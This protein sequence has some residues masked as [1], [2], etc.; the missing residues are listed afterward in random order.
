MRVEVGKTYKGLINGAKFKIIEE[1]HPRS[2]YDNIVMREP[3][4]NIIEVENP[5]KKRQY[6]KSYLEHLL[7]E[8]SYDSE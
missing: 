2:D 3:Y 7:I 4:Y 1:V 5:D 8:E 6:S